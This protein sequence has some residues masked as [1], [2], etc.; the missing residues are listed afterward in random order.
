MP[1]RSAI[2]LMDWLLFMTSAAEFLNCRP[3]AALQRLV[4]EETK[5]AAQTA[6]A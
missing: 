1:D 3:P 2:S 5:V 4:A 6:A